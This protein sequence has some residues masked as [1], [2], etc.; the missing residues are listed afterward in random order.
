MELSGYYFVHAY[1]VPSF[2]ENYPKIKY[3]IFDRHHN[4][5]LASGEPMRSHGVR[6]RPLERHVL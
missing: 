2:V 6:R 1:L 4:F 3:A 5:S